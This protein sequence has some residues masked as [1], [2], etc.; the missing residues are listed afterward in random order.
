MTSTQVKNF[1]LIVAKNAVNALIVN[2]SAWFILPANF[3]F[4]DTASEWNIAKLALGTIVA[5]EVV[6]WGPVILKWSNTDAN[7]SD[8]SQAMGKAEQASTKA[9]VASQEAKGAIED[10]KTV[11]AKAEE[12]K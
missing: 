5:R 10:A 3:N 12:K 9:V 11:A 8:L 1:F 6:V 2:A 7:P 4:H